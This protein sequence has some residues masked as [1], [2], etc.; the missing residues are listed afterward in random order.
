MRRAASGLLV[1]LALGG[2]GGTHTTQEESARGAV[3]TLIQTCAAERPNAVLEVLNPPAR[4][5]FVNAGGELA[6]CMDVLGVRLPGAS[7]AEL[8]AIHVG[9]VQANDLSATASL[10]APGGVRSRVELEKSRGTWY[11]MSPR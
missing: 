8:R 9:S 6:G 5:A 11:V 4:S 1:I 7:A 3:D 10:S 2:C